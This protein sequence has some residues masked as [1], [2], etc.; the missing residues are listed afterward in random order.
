MSIS[1]FHGIRYLDIGDRMQQDSI[2]LLHGFAE[3]LELWE[4]Y[5]KHLSRS[6]RVIV[7]DLRGHTPKQ[8]VASSSW[9]ISDMAWDIKTLLDHCVIRKTFVVGHSLGGYVGLAM[10]KLFPERMR[11]LSLFHSHPFADSPATKENRERT[12]A[13]LSEAKQ[14]EVINALVD[15]VLPE[16]FR[17]SQPAKT[18]ALR[19]MMMRTPAE[20]LVGATIA[21]RDRYD[22]SSVLRGVKF[23]VQFILGGEDPIVNVEQIFALVPSIPS[24][25]VEFLST[26]GH[27]GMIESP[28]ICLKLLQGF[29]E[30][31]K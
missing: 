18:E 3:Q 22:M 20:G 8:K 13:L 15:R 5:A 21:M 11:S 16:A 12:I 14:D 19:A 31:C 25:S 28:Q 2:L 27:Q 7:P 1:A 30:R 6:Y 4:E 26:I 17:K 24:V 29:I 23:P 10:A 9:T